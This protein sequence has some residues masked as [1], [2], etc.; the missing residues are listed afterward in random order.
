MTATKI[1]FLGSGSSSG[2]PGIGIGWGR[3]NPDNPKNNR[4]RQSILVETS[5][6]RVL[7]DTSPDLRQQLLRVGVSDID[8]VL[9]THAHADHLNGIDDLRGVNKAIRRPLP[10]FA[11]METHAHIK[12]CFG[13]TLKPLPDDFN[14]VYIR[15]VLDMT[16]F[17]PGDDLDVLGVPVG[18]FLQDHGY[19]RTVGFKFDGC[20]Y[21]T[22]VKALSD[23]VLERLAAAHL[24]VWIIGVFRW[25][26]HW[27]HAHVDLALEWISRVKP[28]RA[29][30]THLSPD[31]DYDELKRYLPD[32]VVPAFDGMTL[33]VAAR[34]GE[35]SISD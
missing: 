12:Q 3:C 34:G 7:V 15:P 17:V 22:D 26:K 21:S 25:E 10:V 33:D 28:K 27:T 31:I 9:F 18:T 29:I 11:N 5:G 4:L 19:S 32:H 1:S 35:V 14:G 2:V 30:L 16:E 23:D 20:V 8:A 24:D 13:Y 6:K